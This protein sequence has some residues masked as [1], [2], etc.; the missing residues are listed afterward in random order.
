MQ[1]AQ[2]RDRIE[3]ESQTDEPLNTSALVGTWINSN[4]D[5]SGIARLRISES[6]AHLLLETQAVGVDGLID[7]GAAKVKLFA[8]SAASRTAGG[9]TSFYDFGFAETA[10]Q[11]MIMKGLLVLAQFHRFKDSS[12]RVDYFVREYFSLEHGRF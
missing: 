1:F 10:L 4:P 8:S 5:T 3:A 12:N 7:W 11:G 6:D 2:I 9:F